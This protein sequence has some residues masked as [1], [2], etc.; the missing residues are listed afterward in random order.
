MQTLKNAPHI[1]PRIGSPK[2]CQRRARVSKDR[3]YE[4][5]RSGEWES[6]LDGRSRKIL[7]ASVDAWIDRQ[8]AE[9]KASG[10]FE[11]ARYPK[12]RGAA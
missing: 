11:R 4:L 1:E 10:S 6:Y 3:A 2:E 9:A 12:R 7:I 5:M 8:I